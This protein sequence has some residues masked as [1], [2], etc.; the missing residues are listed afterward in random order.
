RGLGRAVEGLAAPDQ[1]QRRDRPRRRSVLPGRHRQATLTPREAPMA[2][3]EKDDDRAYK[4]V[5]NGE[6]QYSIWLLDRANPPGWTDVG[7]SGSKADCL[8][9]IKEIWTDMRPGGVRKPS[10]HG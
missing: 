5:V 6:Q 2:W 1:R 4:V 8:A 3:D 10:T 7:K 9:Y